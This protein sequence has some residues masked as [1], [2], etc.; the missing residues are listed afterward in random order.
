MKTIALCVA[1]TFGA[2]SSAIA[3]QAP[4]CNLSREEVTD[5]DLETNL[6]GEW[7]VY[8]HAET[9]EE[10]GQ[11]RH[12]EVIPDKPTNA[13]IELKND[14]LWFWEAG[15]HISGLKLN[16]VEDQTWNFV[17]A[18]GTP[19][20]ATDFLTDEA[21]AAAMGCGELNML[22]RLKASETVTDDHETFDFN[23]YLYVTATDSMYGVA[24]IEANHGEG[25]SRRIV[26]IRR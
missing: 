14:G 10:N 13:V 4:F 22:P 3:E 21:L 25:I 18:E 9:I 24:T 11:V 5:L 7:S 15:S 6:V 16:W 12:I 8:A 1:F 17:P 2:L 26:S 23:V 20:E 19:T